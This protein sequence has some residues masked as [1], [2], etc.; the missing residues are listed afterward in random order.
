MLSFEDVYTLIRYLKKKGSSLSS[1]SAS[2][3]LQHSKLLACS[4]APLTQAN[5][6]AEVVTF[7]AASLHM[8]A[9]DKKLRACVPAAVM[10]WGRF[11][12]RVILNGLLWVL[13]H[14]IIVCC[15]H[16]LHTQTLTHLGLMLIP[17]PGE[18][19]WHV[20]VYC[21]LHIYIIV[22]KKKSG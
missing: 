5:G 8:R 13:G 22:K 19:R 16:V 3:C 10:E 12:K 9:K 15:R 2:L 6:G 18:W 20:V 1:P 21:V 7:T 11:A 4:L 14:W 17:S